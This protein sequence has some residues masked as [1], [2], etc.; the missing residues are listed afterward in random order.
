MNNAIGLGYDVTPV[1][2]NPILFFF[3]TSPHNANDLEILQNF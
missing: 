3:I 1:P 2:T